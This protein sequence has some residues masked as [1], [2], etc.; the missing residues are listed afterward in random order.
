[1]KGFSFAY[2]KEAFVSTLLILAGKRNNKDGGDEWAKKFEETLKKQIKTLADQ[3]DP[4][5]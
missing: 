3:I 4:D 1:M 2:M 5:A